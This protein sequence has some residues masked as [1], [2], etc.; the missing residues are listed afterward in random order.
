MEEVNINSYFTTYVKQ[1]PLPFIVYFLLLFVY[2]IHRIVL[3]KYYG[4]VIANLK[5]N[6]DSKT[7]LEVRT[8]DRCH[9]G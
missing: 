5:S 1:N 7:R 6:F 9:Q 4:I 2:P 8:T 3:P